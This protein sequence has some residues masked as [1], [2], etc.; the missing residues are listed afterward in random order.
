[1]VI[2]KKL[3]L[4]ENAYPTKV[5]YVI[6]NEHIQKYFNLLP[7][8]SRSHFEFVVP[9]D[10]FKFSLSVSH[11]R[12][13]LIVPS[14]KSL[15]IIFDQTSLTKSNNLLSCFDKM[16]SES[17]TWKTFAARKYQ[18]RYSHISLMILDIFERQILYHL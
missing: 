8:D 4:E 17:P 7:N 11:I 1:M 3:I 9:T 13:Q 12:N 15:V 18:A 14:K 16:R 6:F 5:G 10:Q 2:K